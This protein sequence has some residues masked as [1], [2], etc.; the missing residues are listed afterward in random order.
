MPEYCWKKN[1]RM[2]RIS[3]MSLADELRPSIGPRNVSPNYR[4]ITTEKK[5]AITLYYLEDTG[6]LWMTAN[7]FGIHQC[8][9]SKTVY[10]VCSAICINLGPKYLH[11][12][13][14]KEERRQKV[15]EF[16]LKFGMIQAFGCI[17]G[18][19]IPI[20]RPIGNSQDYFNYIQFFSLHIQAVCDGNGQFINVKC[21][22][23]G[24]VHGAKVFANSDINVKLNRAQL[25]LT[26]STVLP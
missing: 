10:C 24:S 23:P 19:H 14:D 11:L 15:S 12:P 17:N 9:V 4:A 8:T 25:P 20:K 18:T 13:R 5:L 6:S 3:F 16:E 26:F 2:S 21:K 7:T 1:F 22:W